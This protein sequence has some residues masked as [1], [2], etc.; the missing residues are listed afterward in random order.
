MELVE[1]VSW[2]DEQLDLKRFAADHANNGLQVQGRA[3]VRSAVFGVDA[4]QA[5][6]DAAQEKKA[7]FIFVHH[8]LS[9]GGG[10]RRL[11]GTTA[12]RLSTL[13]SAGISL[14]AAHLPLDAHPVFGNN[15]ALSDMIGLKERVPFF[16]YDGSEI[17][18]SGRLADPAPSEDIAAYLGEKL[19]TEPLFFGDP[20]RKAA[21][22]AVVSGGAGLDCLE[23][24]SA[25]GC[26]LLVTGE[27]EHV[28]FHPRR[29]LGIGV[30]ALG[31]YASETVGPRALMRKVAETWD[32]ETEF[33]DLPTGL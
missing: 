1:L 28:M 31:H 23:A 27:F 21:R 26:D 13:F 15:A 6:F 12:K 17:G 3:A 33:I 29:E 25:S 11:T 16:E 7:D 10:L 32:L 20:L 14:Y 4:C 22:I 18:F 9:W 5:L 24:A 8:G 30:I 19:G 2:L